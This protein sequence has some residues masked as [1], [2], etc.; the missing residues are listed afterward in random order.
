MSSRPIEDHYIP[1]VSGASDVSTISERTGLKRVKLSG[2]RRKEALSI[3]KE[4]WDNI[5]KRPAKNEFDVFGEYVASELRGVTGKRNILDLK[6]QIQALIYVTKL[7]EIK[8]DP[9][10]SSRPTASQE[11]LSEPRVS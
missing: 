9:N 3:L 10:V 5:V 7:K 11:Q 2:D 8:G 4:A 6:K 1:S